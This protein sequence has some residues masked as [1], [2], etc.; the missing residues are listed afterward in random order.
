[1]R[2]IQVITGVVVLLILILIF[3]PAFS[4]QFNNFN[5][6]NY[7]LVISGIIA[8]SITMLAL[9]WQFA[10][11][12]EKA[13]REE[14]V[15]SRIF[16][17]T[18]YILCKHHNTG[19]PL[20]KCIKSDICWGIFDSSTI[21]AFHYIV[22]ELQSNF[23]VTDCEISTSIDEGSVNQGTAGVV[24]PQQRFVFPFSVAG[25]DLNKHTEIITTY[26]TQMNEKLRHRFI[27]ENGIENDGIEVL[28]VIHENGK[29]E[30]IFESKSRL[31]KLLS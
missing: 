17:A 10:N 25:E 2:K 5:P 1:V 23:F 3:A 30:Q 15:K 20:W 21:F 7:Y 9:I 12:R 18:K 6:E 14:K 11:E 8:G 24:V 22:F 16:F 29:S 27:F 28:E 26:K 19:N 13:R 31:F 4:S